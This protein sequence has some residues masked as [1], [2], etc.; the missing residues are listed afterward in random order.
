MSY[1]KYIKYKMKY[2]KLKEF[3]KQLIASGKL[4]TDYMNKIN[5]SGGN[6]SSKICKNCYKIN[7]TKHKFCNSCNTN[8]IYK[9]SK[10]TD[11]PKMIDMYGYEYDIHQS[12]Y[13]KLQPIQEGGNNN[14]SES[15]NG[16]LYSYEETKINL[17]PDKVNLKTLSNKNQLFENMSNELTESESV[18]LSILNSD[19]I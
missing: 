5:Q 12:L 6:K 3:E 8:N 11:T 18:A 10:L 1:E 7:T 14:D 17:I 9:I 4:P 2:I 15:E 13:D 19:D 16:D